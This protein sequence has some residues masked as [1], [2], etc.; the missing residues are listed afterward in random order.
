MKPDV[1]IVDLDPIWNPAGLPLARSVSEACPDAHV[2]LMAPDG[3]PQGPMVATA[4]VE[5]GW[6]AILRR[7]A[8]NG[9]RLMQA[10]VAGLGGGSWIDPD[11]KGPETDQSN[12]AGGTGASGT[13]REW[14]E[15]LEDDKPDKDGPRA[16]GMDLSEND[17][18]EEWQRRARNGMG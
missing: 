5:P 1:T 7:K 14:A 6:S 8:D 13:G 11:L 16:A 15:G 2:I 3:Y 10:L 9:E 17:E 4:A 18:I 12:E